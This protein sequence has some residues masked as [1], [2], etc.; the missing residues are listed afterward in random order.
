GKQVLL[1]DKASFPRDKTCGDGLTPRALDVLDDMGIL[2]QAEAAGYRVNGLSV[3]AKRGA[4]LRSTIPK[5]PSLHDY[6]LVV[7]RLKLDDIVR[8]RAL[9]QG[10][11]FHGDSR[12]TGLAPQADGIDIHVQARGVASTYRA[13]VAVVAAGANM[14]FLREIGILKHTPRPIVAVRA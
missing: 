13:Q 12:V 10:V 6:L 4:V 3:F 7:P 8:H 14:S 5:H 2:A 9:E 11:T 1:L